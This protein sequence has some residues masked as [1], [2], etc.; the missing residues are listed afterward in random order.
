[1]NIVVV[2]CGGSGKTYTQTFKG[3]EE[4]KEFAEKGIQ[5]VKK[6]KNN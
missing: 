4:V 2:V 3:W 1:M 6:I 5:Y